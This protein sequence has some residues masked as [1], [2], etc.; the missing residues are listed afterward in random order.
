MACFCLIIL[1]Q[2]VV[3]EGISAMLVRLVGA[4]F[5]SICQIEGLDEYKMSR[6]FFI[7]KLRFKNIYIIVAC[8]FAFL[9][10]NFLFHK[11]T[12]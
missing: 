1:F 8:S 2:N 3:V 5:V 9:M 7:F 4:T 6:S 12:I 10:C 11:D